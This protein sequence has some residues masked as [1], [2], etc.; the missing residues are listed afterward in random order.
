MFD[1]MVMTDYH[2][3]KMGRTR[4]ETLQYS[5]IAQVGFQY[6]I[7]EK[8]IAPSQPFRLLQASCITR[9]RKNKERFQ[10]C[11]IVGSN[12]LDIDILEIAA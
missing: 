4:L 5:S 6:L 11:V 9:A 8:A 2:R 7:D 12:N 10:R 3:A 1:K